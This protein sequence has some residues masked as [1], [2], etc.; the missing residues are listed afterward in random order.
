MFMLGPLTAS[1]R[2]DALLHGLPTGFLVSAFLMFSGFMISESAQEE[3]LPL[4]GEGGAGIMTSTCCRVGGGPIAVCIRG[5]PCV[6]SG[7]DCP[8]EICASTAFL[9]LGE[10]L[11][12]VS[13]SA[14]LIGFFAV[15]PNLN[16]DWAP[17][18]VPT[19]YS[20]SIACLF[21]SAFLCSSSLTLH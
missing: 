21:A 2:D 5:D 12:H 1:P 13:P 18:D 20:G 19:G 9:F 3:A 16:A 4:R 17:S 10:T 14:R 15:S 8:E 11:V 6:R 7:D